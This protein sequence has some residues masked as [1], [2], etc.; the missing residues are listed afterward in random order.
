MTTS[1]AESS[2]FGDSHRLAHRMHSI[3]CL[4]EIFTIDHVLRAASASMPLAASEVY[5]AF[6]TIEVA[7]EL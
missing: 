7:V 1:I 5:R 4:D 6:H 2:H 3:S